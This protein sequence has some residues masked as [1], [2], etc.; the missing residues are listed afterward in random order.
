MYRQRMRQQVH[1]GKFREYMEIA[2]RVVELR[3][4]RGFATPTLFVPVFGT[5]NEVIWEVD[6]PDLAIFQREN[7]AFHADPEVMT[8]WRDLWQLAVQ[9]S[10]HDEL[11]TE[12]PH[13]A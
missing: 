2:E 5:A 6:Y 12:A 7:D 8:Q 13:I 3:K 4:Q 11:L 10:T 9:G 1:Y